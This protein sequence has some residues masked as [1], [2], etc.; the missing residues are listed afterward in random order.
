MLS[1]KIP[2]CSH[3]KYLNLEHII[4]LSTWISLPGGLFLRVLKCLVIPMIFCNMV[5]GVADLSKLGQ[6]GTIGART[7]A[8]YM[9][10]TV[11]GLTEAKI[12]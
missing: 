3:K 7:F 4:P 9:C 11:R 12:T 1:Q 6:Q 8:L 5:M 10:T 2:K